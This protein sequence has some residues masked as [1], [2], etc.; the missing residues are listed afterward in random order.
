VAELDRT[1]KRLRG[2]EASITCNEIRERLGRLRESPCFECARRDAHFGLLQKRREL[3]QQHAVLRAECDDGQEEFLKLL[4]RHRSLLSSVGCIANE[5]I[6][7]KGRIAIEMTTIANEL[8]CAE[9]I[10]QNFFDALPPQDIAALA[11]CLVAERLGKQDEESRVPEHLEEK[12]DELYMIADA[13]RD[14]MRNANVEYD[15]DKRDDEKINPAGKTATALRVQGRPFSQC[16]NEAAIPE[17]GLVRLLVQTAAQLVCFAKGAML[18]GNKA[19]ADLFEEAGT[20]MKRG[21]IFGA[22]LYLD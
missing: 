22:S 6:T 15:E 17:G 8:I 3:E 5:A 9:L 11:S 4:N 7:L 10:V 19:I 12:V 2:G 16:L 14:E 18:V 20:M 13:L 1:F 21:I